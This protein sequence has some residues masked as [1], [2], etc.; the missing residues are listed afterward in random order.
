MAIRKA[1]RRDKVFNQLN[2]INATI[3]INIMAFRADIVKMVEDLVTKIEDHHFK[4]NYSMKQDFVTFINSFFKFHLDQS[5]INFTLNANLLYADTDGVKVIIATDSTMAFAVP[6]CTIPMRDQIEAFIV[7]DEVVAYDSYKMRRFR[8]AIQDPPAQVQVQNA[9][10]PA[11]AQIAAAPAAPHNM[12]TS[13]APATSIFNAPAPAPSTFNAPAPAPSTFNAPA[14]T[15]SAPATTTPTPS[16]FNFSTPPAKPPTSVTSFPTPTPAATTTTSSSFNF[17]TAPTT[18][19][20]FHLSTI[21]AT[22]TFGSPTNLFST[23]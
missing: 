22:K 7:V 17:S 6:G 5:D 1:Y 16:S 23:R 13:P 8:K 18:T 3:T 12:F 19:S 10:A 20:A 4:V 15:A 14:P 21:P 11:P 2:K 9:A